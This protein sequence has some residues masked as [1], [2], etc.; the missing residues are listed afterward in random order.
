MARNPRKTKPK[1]PKGKKKPAKR[2]PPQNRNTNTV[3][4]HVNLAGESAAAPPYA[5]P[6]RGYFAF[7]PV[8]DVGGPKQASL[9]PMNTGEPISAG[10]VRRVADEA[11]ASA[12]RP[13]SMGETSERRVEPA[14]SSER[15]NLG[16]SMNDWHQMEG[17]TFRVEKITKPELRSMLEARG[18]TGLSRK[19]KAELIGIYK[20][21]IGYFKK[22][23]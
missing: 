20:S 21:N 12:S 7:N 2:A 18:I 8:F 17:D 22:I 19:T 1:K 11:E 3:K 9:P 13:P 4:V 6:D 16:L 14:G 15:L 10:P 5:G 23:N